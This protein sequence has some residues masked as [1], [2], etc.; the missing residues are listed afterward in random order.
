MALKE[1]SIFATARELKSGSLAHANRR[2]V[3]I[4]ST[5]QPLYVQFELHDGRGNLYVYKDYTVVLSDDTV[6][7]GI[8]D[9]RGKT[10][11]INIKGH[12]K[13]VLTYADIRCALALSESEPEDV[14]AQKSALNALGCGA[15][16]LDGTAGEA[17][18]KAVTQF[19]RDN[20]LKETGSLGGSDKDTLKKLHLFEIDK[21]E[22]KETDEPA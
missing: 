1:R 16:A 9:A 8:T 22:T 10:K 3:F 13:G 12:E 15:G 20:K 19:Q 5:P 18:K 14:I 4:L 7:N 11:R 2:N 6:I 17:F 21:P